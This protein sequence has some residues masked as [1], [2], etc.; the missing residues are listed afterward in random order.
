MI[1]HAHHKAMKR[2][3]QSQ[4]RQG[5]P[6]QQ[7]GNGWRES[8]E[9]LRVL[10][11]WRVQGHLVRCWW[12][13][14]LLPVSKEGAPG[15][16]HQLARMW[17]RSSKTE[18]R[19]CLQPMDGNHFSRALEGARVK[20]T[21]SHYLNVTCVRGYSNCKGTCANFVMRLC[22]GLAAGA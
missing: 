1:P 22:P 16:S 17:G 20:N 14:K 8:K 3:V 5:R 19:L 4:G 15:P 18:G 9:W 11:R 2:S 7:V 12:G 6:L 13:L 21:R 10:L